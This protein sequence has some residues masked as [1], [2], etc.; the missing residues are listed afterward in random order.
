MAR[1][2]A[3]VLGAGIVGTSAALQLVKRGLSVAL[4]DRRGPGEETSYGNTGIIGGSGP[5]PVA[6]PRRLAEL[7]AITQAYAAR[8]AALGGIMLAGDARALHRANGR[9][10]IETEQG[11]VDTDNVVVALGPW[12]PDL[13]DPLGIKLP[14]GIKRGYHRHFRP[15]GNAALGR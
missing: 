14:L 6:F 11:H 15:R 7:L 12:A 3:I 1:T 13:L 2:D 10:R 4:V 5:L 8:F 9:W